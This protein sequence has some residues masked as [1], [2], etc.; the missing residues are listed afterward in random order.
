VSVFRDNNIE[1]REIQ[2][3]ILNLWLGE[4][5]ESKNTIVSSENMLNFTHGK[6]F[7]LRQERM[8]GKHRIESQMELSSA[9]ASIGTDRIANAD[10]VQ[11][12][13][14][15]ESIK[16]QL[17]GNMQKSMIDSI[18]ESIPEENTTTLNFSNQ[19]ELENTL[20]ETLRS[21]EPSLDSELKLVKPSMMMPDAA[22]EKFQ[23]IG[24]FS[25]GYEEKIK[26]LHEE[27][28]EQ[29]LLKH[30]QRLQRYKIDDKERKIISDR[31]QQLSKT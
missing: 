24:K 11:L 10:F 5:A 8:D 23:K 3:E 14:T 9:D 4:V 31:Q 27:K 18:T 21:L 15:L 16:E 26:K 29:A 13:K 30:F 22:F 6:K 19:V 28:H 7:S 25:K 1:K 2:K 12:A 20:Y 17:V